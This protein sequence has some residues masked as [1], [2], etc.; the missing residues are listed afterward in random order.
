[1]TDIIKEMFENKT[2]GELKELNKM[3]GEPCI[4]ENKK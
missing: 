3:S 4:P 1:M 2:L